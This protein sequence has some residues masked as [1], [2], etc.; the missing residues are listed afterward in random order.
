M[1]LED[2]LL[3]LQEFATGLYFKSAEYGPHLSIL[4]F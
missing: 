2:S 4:I 3:C 1:E